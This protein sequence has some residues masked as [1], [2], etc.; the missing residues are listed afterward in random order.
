MLVL[1]RIGTWVAGVDLIVPF[2][3]EWERGVSSVLLND[4]T[5]GNDVGERG[6]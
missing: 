5:E 4:D 2:T 6:R 1:A 3:L